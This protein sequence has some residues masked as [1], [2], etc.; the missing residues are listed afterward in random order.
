MGLEKSRASMRH[1]HR[2]TVW[3]QVGLCP[4][5][6]TCRRPKDCL[7][8]QGFA[9]EERGVVLKKGKVAMWL[10]LTLLSLVTSV[11]VRM[12]THLSILGPKL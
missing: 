6:S 11:E 4:A 1:L 9:R 10:Y 12:I 5:V 7:P 2:E 3:E 8:E